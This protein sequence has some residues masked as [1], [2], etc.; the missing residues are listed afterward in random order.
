[1][2]FAN[3]TI[4][5]LIKALDISAVEMLA[6][7]LPDSRI[8][9]ATQCLMMRWG[10]SRYELVG[11]QLSQSEKSK[12]SARYVDEGISGINTQAQTKIEVTYRPDENTREVVRFKP[13]HVREGTHEYLLLINPVGAYNTGSGK[14]MDHE[15]QA[16]LELA[17][18]A[19]GYGNWDYDF[20]NRCHTISPELYEILGYSPGDSRLDFRHFEDGVHPDDKDRTLGSAIK[21]DP[22]AKFWLDRFRYRN[23]NDEYLW[24]EQISAVVRDP[25]TGDHVKVIGL[26][27]N[28]DERMEEL[29]RLEQ[30]QRN[31]ARSQEI[32]RVGSWI[33]D[34][35]TGAIEWSDQMYA[36][37]G[38]NRAAD[39]T[40]DPILE[41]MNESHRDRWVENIELAKLGTKIKPFDCDITRK[42]GDVQR[43]QIHIDA[44]R[45][46][47]GSVE[48]LHGICQDITEQ[49]LLE[50][51]FLQAQKMESVGRLTGGI[52]HDFNNLLMVMVG[53]L[54]LLEQMVDDTDEK[55]LK[56]IHAVIEAANKGSELTKRMLAFSRQQ[57]LEDE[58]LQ[59]DD[60]IGSMKEMLTRAIGGAIELE[61][62]A[63]EGLWPVATDRTQLET[64]ILNLAINARDAMV[65]G[66]SLTIETANS[67]LDTTYCRQYEDLAPGAYVMI[68]VTDTGQGMPAEI[69]DKVVQ[70][71]FTTK[72]PEAGS[73]LGLSMIYGF[74]QQSGG[75]LK[76]TSEEGKGTT[77]K[78]Y[79]PKF[80]KDAAESSDKVPAVAAAE[81]VTTQEPPSIEEPA[82]NDAK[83]QAATGAGTAEDKPAHKP[84][85]AAT[86]VEAEPET[87]VEAK[88]ETKVEAEPDTKVEAEP[89]TKV[90]AEG[91]KP[92]APQTPAADVKAD[93][94]AGEAAPA[95]EP[96]ERAKHL[97]LVVE[98][99]DAVR[100]V[101][102][103][104]VEDMGYNVLEASN[105]ADALELIKSHPEIDLLLSDV[106][107]A[108][109]NGPELAAEAMKIRTDLKVLFASGY[110]QGAAEEM[111]DLPNFIELINKPFTRAEL[112]ERVGDA[113]R[114]IKEQAA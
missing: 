63:G 98:D 72:P 8:V 51:K 48:T 83:A 6:I 65:D 39:P 3:G 2:S 45:T 58:E 67:L 54:Q 77:I 21:R 91:Q 11:R 31:L 60:L 97:V 66:G 101:A 12:L 113:I 17:V 68:S 20:R 111:Q 85:E 29:N 99:N 14:T 46:E 4:G 92:C 1:M 34:V 50:R 75:H 105:G 23:A 36:I 47:A 32:A 52:A 24:L 61:V 53:N 5:E 88:P 59:V 64:A 7:S 37:F 76:I 13:Q 41:M 71:F 22:G 112:T 30:S 102:V 89:D 78:I 93:K 35:S 70:P 49:I 19:G 74:V 86:K 81:V 25:L 114:Q 57:T 16:R 44:E 33:I 104:M 55:A 28:I 10:C 56:R 94:S 62:I 95:A 90:E 107:M 18:R 27:R 15:T 84:A 108:G 79:L 100:D 26:L 42:S 87:K 40:F 69:I 106:V 103:A 9:D 109:M 82:A 96:D 110:T 38:F 43:I 80:G 73:G